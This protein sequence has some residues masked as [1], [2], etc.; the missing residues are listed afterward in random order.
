MQGLGLDLCLRRRRRGRKRGSGTSDVR[1]CALTPRQNLLLSYLSVSPRLHRLHNRNL[2]RHHPRLLSL[3]L[4]IDHMGRSTA[5]CQYAMRA[6]NLHLPS[7][8]E[9]S[10]RNC[11]WPK[12]SCDNHRWAETGGGSSRLGLERRGCDHWHSHRRCADQLRSDGGGTNRHLRRLVSK[13]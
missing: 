1:G 9:R 4:P 6:G 7:R 11:R 12:H 5:H 8:A 10:G 13:H 3:R 2:G